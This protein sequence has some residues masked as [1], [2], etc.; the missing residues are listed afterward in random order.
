MT[1]RPPAKA[2]APTVHI[3]F[4]SD[5]PAASPLDTVNALRLLPNLS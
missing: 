5:F 3:T 1:G 2:T 4:G